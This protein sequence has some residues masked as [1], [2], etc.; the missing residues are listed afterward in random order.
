MAVITA[1]IGTTGRDY[2]TPQLWEDAVPANLSSDGNARVGAVYNDGGA[3]LGSISI[4]AHTTDA[5]NYMRLTAA[6]GQSFMDNGS[7]RTT[8][9]AFSSATYAALRSTGGY[10]FCVDLTGAVD[11]FT[12]DR[13]MIE[14]TA[15]SSAPFSSTPGCNHNLWKDLICSSGNTSANVGE[16]WG[17]STRLTNIVYYQNSGSGTP[18]E[19]RDTPILH[20]CTFIRTTNN[21]TTGNGP[22]ARGYAFPTMISCA[23]FGYTAPVAAAG[24]GGWDAASKNNASQAASG[25]PGSSNQHSVT[26]SATTPFTQASNSS[27]DLR[28]VASTSLASNGFLDA[29]NA[30]SD[31]TGTSRAA[32]PTIG[33]WELAVASGHPT[34]KRH[35]GVP[36]MR[37]GGATFGQGWVH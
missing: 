6:S 9:L 21:G 20:G 18:I 13:L 2:S 24:S 34:T 16:I 8:A 25:L 12:C 7:V 11:Y 33:A 15:S 28:A 3:A 26:F 10:V 1:T 36:F 14:T 27:T 22:R 23:V 5:T 32:S 17:T 4:S 37:L 19:F 30:P 31:I 29:T 35:G